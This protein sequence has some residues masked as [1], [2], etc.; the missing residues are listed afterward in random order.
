[1][2]N[3]EDY[4]LDLLTH[5]L[6]NNIK[7]LNGMTG[8]IVG[9]G[10]S[11]EDLGDYL[12]ALILSGKSDHWRGEV[13]QAIDLF[14]SE[15]YIHH[16]TGKR[17][18]GQFSRCYSQTDLFWGL[19][20]A[21]QVDDRYIEKYATPLL[22]AR[23]AFFLPVPIS[24]ILKIVPFTKIELPKKFWVSIPI[25]SA[26]DHGMFVEIFLRAYEQTG[27]KLFFGEAV[28]LADSLLST[29][30]Y[31]KYSYFEFYTPQTRLTKILV[32]RFRPF[33]KRMGEFQLLK[34]NSNIMFGLQRFGF[35]EKKYAEI[36]VDILECWLAR[37]YDIEKR[38]FYTNY[39]VIDNR[40]SADLTVF[41]MVELLI[42][43]GKI[44]VAI[45]IV[46]SILSHQS[47]KTGLI[48]FMHP[49]AEQ[50]LMRLNV[51]HRSSWLDSEVD[52]GVSL[53]RLYQKTENMEYLDA[54][55]RILMGINDLH[56][57]KFGFCKEVD[58]ETGEPINPYCSTKTAA[59]VM[60]LPGAIKG[61]D[62]INDDNSITSLILQDR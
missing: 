56:R 21:S 45:E 22:A 15:K 58:Y 29:D 20:V 47:R 1:M 62:K 34:Q 23:E 35:H 28:R 2:V 55:E 40:K 11:I 52:F 37:F 13:D 43:A 17:L 30:C 32:N 31:K 9:Y 3:I 59:L 27:I 54:A 10:N 44:D 25:M 60:K 7:S 42:L 39:N 51:S 46:E 16:D 14:E 33:A 4:I 18:K 50:T 57:K 36:F 26:E 49:D 24:Y 19:I 6:Q 8:D 48:P 61:K 41:H 5:C 12:P 53:V 38:I